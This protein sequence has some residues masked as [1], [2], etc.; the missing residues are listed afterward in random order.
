MIMAF[1]CFFKGLYI[2]LSKCNGKLECNGFACLINISTKL[3]C[4]LDFV[5]EDLFL[6]MNVSLF[7]DL[8]YIA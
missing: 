7:K 1:Q 5:I 8:V 2:L 6:S 4:V 3:F